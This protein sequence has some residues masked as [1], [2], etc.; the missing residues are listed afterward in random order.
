MNSLSAAIKLEHLLFARDWVVL[1][2]PS[3]TS[4]PFAIRSRRF[5]KFDPVTERIGYVNSM[6]TGEKF[7]IANLDARIAKR[8]DQGTQFLHEQGR[9]RLSRR[10]K[11]LLDPKVN[12]EGRHLKPYAAASCERLRFGNLRQPEQSGIKFARFILPTGGHGKLD[13]VNGKNRH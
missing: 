3:A 11:I 2:L 8:K 12:P 1:I 10:S 5:Q 7:V 13:V 4:L 9:V 6:I